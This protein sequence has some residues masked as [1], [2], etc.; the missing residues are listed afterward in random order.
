MLSRRI[1]IA[2]IAMLMMVPAGVVRAL[3]SGSG[4]PGGNAAQGLP[5]GNFVIYPNIELIYQ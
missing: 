2:V 3:D 4:L 5:A 1:R